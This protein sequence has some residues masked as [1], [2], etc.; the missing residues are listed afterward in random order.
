M[1]PNDNCRRMLQM[2]VIVLLLLVAGECVA[3]DT[4]APIGSPALTPRLEDGTGHDPSKP[5]KS[6]LI[7]AIEI[8]GFDFALNRFDNRF[9]DQESYDVSWASIRRNLKSKWVVDHDAFETNQ[10]L[11]PYQG[12]VYHTAARS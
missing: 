10:F 2:R 8:I 6:Y 7:P 3:Q 9:I 11:H 5:R 12:S 4:G 1:T